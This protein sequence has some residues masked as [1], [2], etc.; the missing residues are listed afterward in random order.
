MVYKKTSKRV[1]KPNKAYYAPSQGAMRRMQDALVRYDEVVSAKE[2]EW[3]VDRLPWLAGEA[4]RARFDDQMVKLNEAIE[5]MQDVEHQC[6][7]TL[8]GVAALE[9]AAIDAGY[10]PLTGEYIEGA[11]PDGRV[12]A[13]V[14]ND[15]EV[16]R[17]KRDNP[18]LVVYSVSEVAKIIAAFKDEGE[19]SL[20]DSVKDV[21]EGAVVEKVKTKTEMMLNDEVP[22]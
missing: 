16:G 20:V 9:R 15:Y 11:M 6:E 21:F 18:H 19:P 13:V 14:P 17:V 2:R 8:R 22:F 12:L 10:K 5:S 1:P 7:V 4:L 3:G